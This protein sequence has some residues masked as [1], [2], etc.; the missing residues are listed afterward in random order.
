MQPQNAHNIP[1]FETDSLGETVKKFCNNNQYK[2]SSYLQATP[3]F[4]K[5]AKEG[6]MAKITKSGHPAQFMPWLE[7]EAHGQIYRIKS[8]F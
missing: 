2:M 7:G 6:Q 5:V 8:D 1:C 3:S 4:Q